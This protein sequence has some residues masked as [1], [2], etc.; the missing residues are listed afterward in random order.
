MNNA[1]RSTLFTLLIAAVLPA[2]DVDDDRQRIVGQLESDRIELTAEVAEPIIERLV[3]EGQAVAAGQLLIRQDMT[4]ID[5]HIVEAKATASQAR[6]RLDELIRGPRNEQIDAAQAYVRGAEST[7]K[8]RTM[9]FERAEQVHA[10]NLAATEQLDR[11]MAARS[12]AQADLDSGRARLEELLS[13]TT[14]EELQQA[15]AVLA[16]AQARLQSLGVDASRHNSLAPVA[17]VVD[18][19]LFETG[20]RPP[21]GKPLLVLLP[22]PQPH[23][24]VFV[25]EAMRVAVTPGQN[26]RVYVDGLEQSLAGRVRWVSSESAFTPYYALTERD[27]GRLTFAAKVDILHVDQRLPDGVPVEVEILTGR[28][29]E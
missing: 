14:A 3:I 4:R 19:I 24:R 21:V 26:A 9:E 15:E 28:A 29:G 6:A 13:G 23:A 20:E 11:A 16:Q 5:A 10:R 27:R 17:G 22:G 7:L 25:P 18:S 8:F 1:R 12:A 2:C